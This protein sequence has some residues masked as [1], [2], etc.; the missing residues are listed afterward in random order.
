MKVVT[1]DEKKKRET[2]RGAGL[3]DSAPISAYFSPG[4]NPD[5]GTVAG[6]GELSRLGKRQLDPVRVGPE[7]LFGRLLSGFMVATQSFHTLLLRAEFVRP[8]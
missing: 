2:T 4:S 5:P 7:S 1:N 3:A 6:A 8:R